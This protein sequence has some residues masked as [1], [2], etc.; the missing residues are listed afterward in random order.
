MEHLKDLANRATKHLSVWDLYFGDCENQKDMFGYNIEKQQYS[1]DH[2]NSWEIMDG[3][4]AKH[5]TVTVD[6]KKM[7][8]I[9]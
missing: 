9:S 1:K 3:E 8:I 4:N 6:G 7:Y 2:E 5:K